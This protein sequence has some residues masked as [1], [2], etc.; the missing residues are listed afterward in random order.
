MKL[1]PLQRYTIYCIMLEEATCDN[2]VT[3]RA[4]GKHYGFLYASN[5]TGFCGMLNVLFNAPNIY[6]H[7]TELRKRKKKIFFAIYHFRSWDERIHALKESIKELE[8]K[9]NV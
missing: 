7:L 4:V 2:P 9:L 1:T 5:E 6:L 8:E 3:V